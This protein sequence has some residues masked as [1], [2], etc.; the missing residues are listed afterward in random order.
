MVMFEEERDLDR[1]Y[2]E[3]T[4]PPEQGAQI[5]IG[6]VL[7]RVASPAQVNVQVP[8]LSLVREHHVLAELQRQGAHVSSWRRS[9]YVNIVPG[10]LIAF[11]PDLRSLLNVEKIHRVTAIVV[12]GLDASMRAWVSAFAPGHLGGREIPPADPLVRDP[13]VWQAMREFTVLINSSTGLHH[14]SDRSRVTDGLQR[15]RAAGHHF[16]PDEILAA[17]LRLNWRAGAAWDL[18]VLAAEINAGKRKRV[19]DGRL[20]PGAVRRWEQEI[21]E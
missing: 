3:A 16:D 5:A 1:A 18:R 2:V 9:G 8:L 21:A 14:P 7:S 15:L 17:A 19:T 20:G 4:V 13:V 11:S 12:V 10:P 6:W